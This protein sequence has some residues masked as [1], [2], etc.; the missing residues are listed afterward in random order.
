MLDF[1]QYICNTMST[2]DSKKDTF[3]KKL[4]HQYRLVILNDD[5]FEERLSFKLTR[6]NVFILSGFAAI[7]LVALT[8]LLIAFTPLREY[9]PGYSSTALRK[10]ANTLVSKTDSLEQV[11]RV[12]D[13]YYNSIR[14]V[15]IGDIPELTVSR[16]SI[17][18]VINETDG[19][20][21]NTIAEDSLLREVVD[22]ED[23]Y[24]LFESAAATADFSLFAPLKGTLTDNYN[25]STKHLGVDIVA[26]KDTPILAVADGVVIFAEWTA[27]TGYVIILAHNNDLI[28]VYKHNQSLSVKQGELVKAGEAIAVIGN[29]G[30]FSTG[31]HLHLELWSNGYSINPLDLI[32]FN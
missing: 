13:K 6:L 7:V 10:K 1:R 27:Q 12:N 18:V 22:Q 14:S 21:V 5:S 8:T 11:I 17:Q 26:P 24:N 9:I 30:E 16:D 32:D 15:L 3:K 19:L 4:L 23:K 25:T 20:V 31:P 2:K 29:S 28:S